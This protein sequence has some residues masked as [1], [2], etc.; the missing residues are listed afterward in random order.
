MEKD[1]LTA[2]WQRSSRCSNNG[3]CV[4]VARLRGGR[5]AIRD[6]KNPHVH[7]VIVPDAVYEEFI[8]SIK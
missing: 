3:S 2:A 5:V 8:R 6:S 7:P 1:L 4:E